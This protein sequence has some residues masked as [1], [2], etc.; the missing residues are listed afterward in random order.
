M[1]NTTNGAKSTKA[2]GAKTTAEATP[3]EAVPVAERVTIN[4]EHLL[5]LLVPGNVER[6]DGIGWCGGPATTA[7]IYVADEI[8]AVQERL[9]ECTEDDLL[10]VSNQLYRL[11]KRTKAIAYVLAGLDREE[12]AAKGVTP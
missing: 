9:S 11:H 2:N 4:R 12:A 8:E 5:E 10:L 6:E 7:L 3:R 1:K